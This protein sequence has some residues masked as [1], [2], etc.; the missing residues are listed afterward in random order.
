MIFRRSSV[1]VQ[2]AP[3]WFR[4]DSVAIVNGAGDGKRM[5]IETKKKDDRTEHSSR[6]WPTCVSSRVVRTC[7]NRPGQTPNP[8]AIPGERQN[9][10]E[11]TVGSS[12]ETRSCSTCP[13]DYPAT[14][15]PQRE[16]VYR[17][18]VAFLPFGCRPNRS[19]PP[20]PF[21]R[22]TAEETNRQRTP[23]AIRI[24]GGGWKGRRAEG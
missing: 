18:R 2:Y 14:D 12:G 20:Q 21:V 23:C 24:E 16:G 9:Q 3:M 4:V 19:G 7:R 22:L 17:R 5:K 10:N 6:E 11:K 1:F 13:A 15:G 8:I